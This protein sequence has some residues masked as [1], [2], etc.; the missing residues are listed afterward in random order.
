[1][2]A[3]GKTKLII[4]SNSPLAPTGYG[5]QVALFAPMLTEYYD[6]AI[7]AFY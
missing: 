1:M 3:A 6:V 5:Q 4:H 7:S 2:N